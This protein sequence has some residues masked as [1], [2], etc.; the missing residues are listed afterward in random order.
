MSN[1]TDRIEAL[2]T[3][4]AHAERTIQDLSDIAVAQARDMDGLRLELR[5]LTLRLERLEAGDDD[6][7]FPGPGD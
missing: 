4:L 3:A 1:G 6:F 2:E 5:R 7:A